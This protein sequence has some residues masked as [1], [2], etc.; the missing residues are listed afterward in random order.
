MAFLFQYL[1]HAPVFLVCKVNGRHWERTR[2][3]LVVKKPFYTPTLDVLGAVRIDTRLFR[4]DGFEVDGW[5]YEQ[6]VD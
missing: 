4:R 5:I 1:V 3:G 2:L 6:I